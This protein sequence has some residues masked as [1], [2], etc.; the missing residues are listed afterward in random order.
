MN[1]QIA[2]WHGEPFCEYQSIPRDTCMNERL[3]DVVNRVLTLLIAR[4]YGDVEIMT[5][6]VRL[7]AEEIGRAIDEYGRQLIMPPPE[8]YRLMEAVNVKNARPSR[9][10]IAMPLWTREEGRSDLTLEMTVIEQQNG[11]CI[12]L[13]DLHVL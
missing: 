13:E 3:T 1:E 9:W 11:F 6:G 7:D 4:Q 10:S 8:G 12:Q 5:N 2:Q